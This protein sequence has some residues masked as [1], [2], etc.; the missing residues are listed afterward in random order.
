MSPIDII[1]IEHQARQLRAQEMRRIQ[2]LVSA[3]LRVYVRLIGA[4][5]LSGLRAAGKALRPLFS[6]NPQAHHPS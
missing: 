6:W 4:T 3:R 1:A 5:A 2:G